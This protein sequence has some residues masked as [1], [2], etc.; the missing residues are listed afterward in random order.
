[1]SAGSGPVAA[2]ARLP[3][4][5]FYCVSSAEYFLGAAA[6]INSLRL[7]G[8]AER[9]FLLD[10][11]L[12]PEQ[13]EVLAPHVTVV[14]AP[15]DAPPYMLKAVAPRRHPAEVI[16][17]IDADMIVN[18]SLAPLLEEARQGR[19]IAP[20][21]PM[22][23]FFTEWG[24]LLG[25][26]APR[27]LPY[28]TSGLVVL[29]GQPGAEVLRLIDERRSRLD[30]ELSFAGSGAPDYPFHYAD[31]DLLNA[32]LATIV[33]GDRIVALDERLVATIPFQGMRTVGSESRRYAY[34]DGLEPY[35]LHHVLDAKPWLEPTPDGVYSR[36]L[37]RSLLGPDVTLKVPRSQIPL[38]LRTGRLATL[39]RKRVTAEARLRWHVGEP[40]AA[41]LR[42]VRA[43]L[44][45][46]GR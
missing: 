14:P 30:L 28:V 25:L 39:E 21:L 23:R 4:A 1:V 19:V 3:G 43:R 13:R 9:V 15:S 42:K 18:R 41:R 26:G 27:R 8:H 17:L 20:K 40:L 36:V 12:R 29:G 33:S 34:G 6:M 2:A 10:C 32:I 24:E 22:D 45:G 7:A 16:V 38:R 11:G 5:A 46:R 35:V 31:Q 37:T 44:G